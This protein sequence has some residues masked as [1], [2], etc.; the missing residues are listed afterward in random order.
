MAR[1]TKSFSLAWHSLRTVANAP[2]RARTPRPAALPTLAGHG[3]VL[4]GWDEE[5]VEKAARWREYGF[6]YQAFDLGGLRERHR[7]RAFLAMRRETST[8]R[9]FVAC[10]D[11]EP[12]GRISVNLHDSAGLYLWSVH[13]PPEHEGRGICRRMMATLI[14][15]LEEAYP[16]RNFTL[17]TNTFAEHAHRAYRSL[18]F[19][20]AES[21]WHHDREIAQALWTVPPE[22]R[23]TIA[24]HIRFYNGRWEVRAYLMQRVHGAPMQGLDG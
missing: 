12:V 11:G 17:T 24:Q 19:T 7:A 22:Q 20:I 9:H 10:E 8:H 6:P 3:L 21:R 5:L 15:W 1:P 16:A 18:G 13:V 23:E 14:E 4:R 2:A